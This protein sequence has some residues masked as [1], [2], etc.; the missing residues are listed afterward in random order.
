MRSTRTARGNFAIAGDGFSRYGWIMPV[1]RPAPLLA[2]A[3][4]S[5]LQ[6]ALA[7]TAPSGAPKEKY[8]K[9]ESEIPSQPSAPPTTG[10]A[11]V[12]G[13]LFRCQRTFVHQG[14]ILG[15]DSNLR[16]DAER[17]RPFLSKVPAAEAELDAY[18]SNRRSL[19]KLAYIGTAGLGITL[20]GLFISSQFYQGTQNK[21][22]SQGVAF[23]NITTLTGLGIAAGSLIYG[24]SLISRNEKLLGHSVSLYNEAF[25]NDRIELQFSTGFQF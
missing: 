9:E 3:V 8:R 25:P 10:K 4:L 17:L 20:L 15:C 6:P 12:S 23:R 21:L 18:Q 11:P 5:A 13:E 19:R 22:T 24:F 1:F 2:A 7:A 16:L 14:K